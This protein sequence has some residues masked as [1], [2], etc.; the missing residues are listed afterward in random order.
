ML[1]LAV[2]PDRRYH[3]VITAPHV[4]GDA[5]IWNWDKS[6]PERKPEQRHVL[7]DPGPRASRADYARTG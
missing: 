7:E 1:A 3:R 6:V 2:A 5:L 4:G